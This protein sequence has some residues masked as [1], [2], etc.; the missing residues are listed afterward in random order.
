MLWAAPSG[1]EWQDAEP[2]QRPCR[3][4]PLPLRRP[5]GSWWFVGQFQQVATGDGRRWRTAATLSG[6]RVGAW[7]R[8]GRGGKST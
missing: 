7:T 1:L 2:G 8:R 4:R 6:E 5:L 3:L